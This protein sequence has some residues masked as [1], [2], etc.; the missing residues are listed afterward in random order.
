M[1]A[2][3]VA[4]WRPVEY[5]ALK[6]ARMFLKKRTTIIDG[7]C[8][9]W[10][11]SKNHA[12]YGYVTFNG[13]GGLAHRLSWE[14]Y[15]GPVPDGLCVLH[16]C[17]NPGCVNPTHLWVGTHADNAHDRDKKGRGVMCSPGC[18]EDHHSH[19]LTRRQVEMIRSRYKTGC[20]SQRALG[21][22]FGVTHSVIGEIVNN[23]AWA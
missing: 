4:A 16:K 13:I 18:G 20:F 14:L 11:L 6:A 1:D 22:M 10:N 19:K 12:G 8:W 15:H 23:K 17:D 2:D 7:G 5:L 3:R 21:K 9:T